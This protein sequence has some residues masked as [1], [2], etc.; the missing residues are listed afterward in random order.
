M[1]SFLLGVLSS[2]LVREIFKPRPVVMY[3]NHAVELFDLKIGHDEDMRTFSTT[4]EGVRWAWGVERLWLE[5]ES[6][7]PVD[8][9]IPQ[10]F[11]KDWSWGQ[12]HPSEHLERCLKAD[13]SFPILVWDNMIIDGTHRTIK[14]LAQGQKTIKAK[15]IRNIPPPDEQTDLDPVESNKDVHWTNED[16]IRIV[17]AY[18]EYEVIKDYD[19]NHPLDF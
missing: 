3:N 16:M 18:M 13:L 7:E 8:W 17:E 5:F 6:L 12:S 19:F 11:N 14:A 4:I 15:V 10:S 9:E 2:L 1:F